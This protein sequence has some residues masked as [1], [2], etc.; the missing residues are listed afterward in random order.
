MISEEKRAELVEEANRLLP[1][2]QSVCNELITVVQSVILAM[3]AGSSTGAVV[4]P[5]GWTRTEVVTWLR[6][7]AEKIEAE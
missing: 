2:Q 5:N 6:E 7:T 3:R 1:W 4:W